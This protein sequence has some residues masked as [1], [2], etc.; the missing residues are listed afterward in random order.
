[1]LKV[2]IVDDETVVRRG[3]VL[4]VDWASMDC[5]VVGEAA[6]GE[7]GLAAAERYNPNLII[8]DVRMPRMDGIEMMRRLREKESTAH[9]IILT[10]YDEF[11]YARA[12][13]RYGAADYLLKPFR[14]QDLM[15][16]IARVREKEGAAQPAEDTLLLP[17]GDKSK[18]VLQTLNYIA[19]H[20]ADTDINIASIARHIGISEGHLSHVFKKETNLQPWAISPSTA[21]IRPASCCGTAGTRCTRWRRWWATATWPISAARSKSSPACRHRSIRTDAVSKLHKN[22]QFVLTCAASLHRIVSIIAEMTRFAG[23]FRAGIIMV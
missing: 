21:S 1:M 9:F 15:S 16:A 12:A 4:G 10:A 11:D 19:E 22:E 20:Y 6:N 7:E 14:D 2:L 5:V 23:E 17:K 8:T 18:Y 13:L 3:I